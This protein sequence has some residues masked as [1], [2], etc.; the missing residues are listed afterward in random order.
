[1]KLF[2]M[3]VPVILLLAVSL[4]CKLLNRTQPGAVS[5]DDLNRIATNL[6]NFDPNAPPS[7]GVVALRRLAELEPSA[8]TLEREVEAIE[9]ATFKKL[10]ADLQVNVNTGAGP[11]RASQ[12][13]KTR[14]MQVV[15]MSP[16]YLSSTSSPTLIFLQGN[17]GS[18]ADKVQEAAVVAALVSGLS[19]FLGGFLTESGK[20]SKTS[21]ETKDGLTTTMSA[22]LGRGDDGATTFGFGVKTEG[23]KNGVGVNSEMNG[24]IDG[25]RC[26]NAE[27]QVSF[28]VKVRLGAQL[29]QTYYSQE[30][31]AFVR[32]VVND[33]AQVASRTIE[34]IQGTRQV[35]DGR[36]VYVETG[37]D[38]KD[39]GSGAT[40][41][42]YREIRVSGQAK[43]SDG[44][45]SRDGLTAGYAMGLTALHTAETN[46]SN[47]GCTRIE[48]NSPGTVAPNSNS[49]IPVKVRHRFDKSEVPCKLV[50]SLNGAKS[51]DPTTIGR[52]AGTLNYTAPSETGKSATI[53]LIAT[54]RRGRATLD[55]SANTGGQ[56]YT[57]SG[58]S[59]GV[60][61]SGKICSLGKPFTIDA[62]F[63]GGNAKTTFTPSNEAGGA[64]SV[65][66]GGGGCI[67]T[68]GGNYSVTVNQDKSASI[69]WTTTD[70]IACPGFSN[71][72]TATFKLPLQPAPDITCP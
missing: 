60:S 14:T 30:L 29:G 24:K 44:Y 15:A 54:S 23:T 10:L 5:D 1:M 36:S 18:G 4:S 17:A 35:K 58:V 47:G 13:E 31:T 22:E 21:T 57:V 42:N 40:G 52:T 69:T 62:A 64:T 56:S 3:L 61:F 19:D 59:N 66:G 2:R 65:S 50:A 8:T 48:A 25:Q 70:K 7:A 9:R 39:D 71:S 12:F 33:E 38:F 32:A 20:V 68:G 53:N 55:L 41:S 26:P 6:P 51:I 46:W 45:L 49:A 16:S 34:V 28:T 11:K 63:P 72:R 43:A 67:H 27:G 37:E